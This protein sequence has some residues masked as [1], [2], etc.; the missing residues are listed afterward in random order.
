MKQLLSLQ[1][2]YLFKYAELTEVVSQSDQT[3]VDIL[4]S[5][6]LGNLNENTEKHLKVRFIDQSAKSYQHDAFDMYAENVPTVL[7]NQ[8]VLNKLTG[9]VSTH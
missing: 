9:K 1:L 8:T 5:V 4:D 2:W 6:R 7:R 3:F